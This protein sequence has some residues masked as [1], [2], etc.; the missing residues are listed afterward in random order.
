MSVPGLET[1]TKDQLIE[2]LTNRDTFIG[3]V[4]HHRADW[5]PGV[6]NP[7]GVDSENLV[8]T[9]S[10]PLTLNGAVNLLKA[11]LMMAPGVFAIDYKAQLPYF[12]A[13]VI[14]SG[15]PTDQT[16]PWLMWRTAGGKEAL[17]L[18]SVSD[19]A[20]RFAMAHSVQ[21]NIVTFDD[22]NRLVNMIEKVPVD[23]IVL[24]LDPERPSAVSF[25]KA[26]FVRML[27]DIE[28]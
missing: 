28:A 27:R 22:V 11:G 4:I 16:P 20:R 6:E 24:D 14:V 10:P 2:E 21:P 7:Q 23:L 12:A 18:W 9:V 26:E 13:L 25:N 17:A 15:K 5:R 19:D 1:Y 8:L 3:V